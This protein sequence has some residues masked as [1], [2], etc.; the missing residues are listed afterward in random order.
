MIFVDYPGHFVAMLLVV[1]AGVV[2]FAA[3]R[4]DQLRTPGRRRYGPLL[5]LLQIAVIILLLVVLWNP[6]RQQ[7]TR[8]FASNEV[9]TVFDTSESMSIAEAQQ[10][11]RLDHALNAFTSRLHPNNP[12][13]PKYKIYGFDAHAY[14]C[15]STNLLR[16]WG[17]QTNLR[18]ALT[19]ISNLRS[20]IPTPSARLDAQTGV[21][22]IV[23]FTDGQS[24]DKNPRN[25]P[26][27]ADEGLPVMLVGVGARKP[28][29]DI[30]VASI[31]APARVWLKSE[32]TV[33]SRITRTDPSDD[34][35]VVEL[36]CDGQSVES[37]SLDPGQFAVGSGEA[38]VEFKVPAG[39]LGAH[40]LSV[41]AAPVKEEVTTANNSR[42][43]TIEVAQEEPLKVLLFSQWASFDVGK[44]RQ[45]LAWNKRIHL[46]FGLDVVKDRRLSGTFEKTG[47]YVKLPRTDEEYFQYDVIILGPCDLSQ[48]TAEQLNGLFRF[49]V[50]RGGGLML[51]PG[52]TVTSLAAWQDER[53]NA[54]LP[55]LLKETEPR[56]WPPRP[57]VAEVTFEA[58]VGGVFDPNAFDAQE[59]SLSPYYD[60][61][62]VKPAS[63]TL[64]TI[65][66]A[67]L[68]AM[69][70]LGRG[71]VCL[72]NAVK[73]FRLYREDQEGGALTRVLS[74]LLVPLGQT[75]ARGSGIDLFVERKAENPRRAVFTARILD[76][77][78]RPAE[79]ANVLLSLGAEIV[80]MRPMGKGRYG[81]ELDI[82]PAQSVIARVQAESSGAFL[83]ERT[84]VANLP[85]VQDE[86]SDV[87]L[88]EDFL[89]ALAAQ[90]GA[91]YVHI[92]E[93]DDRAGE[94]FQAGRQV[95][96]VQTIR[97]AWPTWSLL[98]IVCLLLA[99]KWF[100]RR[101]IGLV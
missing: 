23:I 34:A 67:P 33:A 30:G 52:P 17:V 8:V 76:K 86:M 16:R 101:A 35:V 29:T 66:G 69:Q 80:V 40:V 49:V 13:G 78:F 47:G 53:G 62:T 100:L 89:R 45:A 97:S 57:D 82:G 92:D 21:A 61:A 31:D 28:F 87:R 63:S 85:P 93:L 9:L 46:D 4:T 77:S 43:T 51:L 15:G 10:A 48:F 14:H 38:Q 74:D 83:G 79:G 6:C 90:T 96:T 84:V 7:S 37:C 27:L 71:R 44:I 41:R 98:G 18:S 99:I 73:L 25:Y 95:G 20:E 50:E 39:Q 54:L 58:E 11:T 68:V 5:M 24:P 26:V 81:A 65:G 2:T 94:A 72:L 32:Y 55:V 12:A 19:E 1:M 59:R 60:V 75:A 91:Q 88:D 64:A 22:G 56:L 42:A 3:F 36:L 70:R